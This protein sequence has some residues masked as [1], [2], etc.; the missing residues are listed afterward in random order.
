MIYGIGTDIADVRRFAK[1]VEN[2]D[3]IERFFN[4]REIKTSGSRQ[5]LQE[6]YASR[7]SVKEAFSKA[8]G[9]GIAGFQLADVYVEH[10]EEGKP[11]LCLEGRAAAL[12]EM[13]CGK[14]ARISVSLSHEKE[15]A[16]AF[17]VI[18]V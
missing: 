1:W 10:D 13:R 16:V 5:K 18:E 6:H 2:P 7:F 3:L 11:E 8:L 14:G 4:K 12:V 15:Y 17:V 9:T